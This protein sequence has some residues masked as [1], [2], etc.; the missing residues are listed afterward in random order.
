MI[1]KRFMAVAFWLFFMAVFYVDAHAD[2]LIKRSNPQIISIGLGNL[3]E[4]SQTVLFRSCKDKE[5][6]IFKLKDYAYQPGR[7]CEGPATFTVVDSL[8]IDGAVKTGDASTCSTDQGC[9][10]YMVN[11]PQDA[12]KLFDGVQKGDVIDVIVSKSKNDKPSKNAT[13]VDLLLNLKGT[14]GG[15]TE[16]MIFKNV[17]ASDRFAAKAAADK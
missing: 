9:L 13:Y 6:K 4:K 11:S 3:D 17:S 7:D 8:K 10:R 15:I 16:T 12:E 2:R 14:K 5:S 1:A